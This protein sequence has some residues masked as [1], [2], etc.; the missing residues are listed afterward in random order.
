MHKATDKLKP[1][2]RVLLPLDLSFFA[3]LCM[4][5]N[6]HAKT[7]LRESKN[8]CVKSSLIYSVVKCLFGY[9]TLE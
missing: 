1:I 9:F 3:L 7:T 2:L 5:Y 8:S 4:G 6:C